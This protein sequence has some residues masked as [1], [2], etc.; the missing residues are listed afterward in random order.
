MPKISV[1]LPCYNA[2]TTLSESLQSIRAQTFTDFELVVVDDGSKDDTCSILS[3]FVRTDS[4][5]QVVTQKHL[6]IVN[7]LNSGLSV[8]RA[9]IVARMDADD[10]SH[11]ERLALQ[12]QFLQKNPQIDI[13]GCLV[14]GF[15]QEELRQGFQSYLAWQNHLT[16]NEDIC[17]E[18]FVESPFPHPSVMYRKQVIKQVGGY[19]DYGWAEDYDLILRLYQNGSSFA[20]VPKFLLEW[21]E[22]A[23]RLTRIDSRYSLENFMRAK[24]HYLTLG[25]LTNRDAIF[26]WG[27]GLMGRRISRYLVAHN[28]PLTAFIDIDPKKIGRTRRGKPVL[29]PD[30]L[31]GYWKRFKSP[32]L[33]AA[34]GVRGARKLIRTRLHKIGL[35][36]GEDWWSVA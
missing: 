2:A 8:C 9:P 34:V 22:H 3:E 28:Q 24:A 33:L 4:R 19:H 7:A 36:E 26:I 27:A 18:I 13:V 23:Q 14:A 35:E 6:G 5:I 15:P 31:L 32:V 30:E 29:H 21:R 17:R 16:T 12:W 10:L 11:P 1:L 20:K 25:P